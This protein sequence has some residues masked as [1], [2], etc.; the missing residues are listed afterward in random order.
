MAS[1]GERR[2]DEMHPLIKE[3]REGIR[4]SRCGCYLCL[5]IFDGSAI[6]AWMDETHPFCP[7]CDLDMVISEYDREVVSID[8]LTRRN[9]ELFGK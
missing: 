7:Y 4:A 2:D 3:R 1:G 8:E 6:K 5:K 9:A